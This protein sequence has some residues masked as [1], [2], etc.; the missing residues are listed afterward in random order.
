[1][2]A[3]ALYMLV[4]DGEASP[5]IACL[6]NSREQARI[7]FEYIS[8]F[9]QSIDRKSEIIK[10]YRNYVATAFNNGSCKVY[11]A[12]SSKLDGLN[13]S[14]GVVDE[15]HEQR[16]RKLYDVLKSSMGMRE[17]PL[18]VVI[19]TA[20]FNLESPCH[21]MYEL[22]IEVL[23]GIKQD[24][25]FFPF[26]F[27]LDPDD[28]WE[29][30]KNWVKCQPNLDVTV[31]R[32]FM[33]GE[34]LKAK[35]DVTA[36]VGV[37]TKTFNLWCSSVMTWIPA[38][39]IA[40]KMSD[41]DLEDYRGATCYC[42]VDLSQVSDLTSLSVFIPY[43]GKYVFKSWT[44]LPEASLKDN[45]NEELYRKFI[46]EG[47]MIVTQGNVTDYDYITAKIVEINDILNIEEIGYDKWNSSSWAIQ[48]TELGFNLQPYGQGVGNFNAPSKEFERLVKSNEESV[49]IDKTANILWQF[50]N[51]SLKV[52]YNN[53]IK[54]VKANASSNRKIDSVISM[55]TA[56]GTYLKKP[57]TSD[58]EIFTL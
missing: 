22:G 50:T 49:I 44:F 54:P 25:T 47:S 23:N 6:G 35:N 31:T 53:N 51:I 55:L 57:N 56:L 21:T 12:D 27:T 37:K 1:M 10:Y 29:D 5:Q 14:L 40:K 45:P 38:E 48:C 18:M 9:G 43:E 30:E 34:L 4:I 33:R 3:L 24:D 46:A 42:G 26:I 36:E 13:I 28:D 8:K 52:D 17:Q 7:L 41:V 58:Y 2:A 11:S 20:G 16:D 15:F 32:E 39:L 19:T